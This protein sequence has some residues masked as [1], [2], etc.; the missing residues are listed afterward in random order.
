MESN[1]VIR[2]CTTLDEF[3]QCIEL[4][5]AVWGDSDRE[6]VPQHIFVVAV[7]TGGQVFGAYDGDRLVGYLLAMVGVKEKR[8]F[9]HSHMTGV[10]PEY[11]NYGIG[12]R[13]KLAQRDDAIARGIDLIEWTFDPLKL[14]NAY[15]NIVRL[16]AIIR[17]YLP[18]VYGQT[19]SHLDRGMPTD[20]FVAEWWITSPRVQNILAGQ[21]YA[22]SANC[23]RVYVPAQEQTIDGQSELR[24]R[25]QT[26]FAQGSAVTWLEVQSGGI[27]YLLEP[28]AN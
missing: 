16:G 22:P 1:I 20:R 12:K 15:F 27:E 10:H 13:L 3:T 5:K 9:I 28:W 6:L 8:V 18:N 2:P 7:K 11:Q 23:Q 19:S 21:P 25:F 26:L 4:Q 24:Q 17:T 14:R